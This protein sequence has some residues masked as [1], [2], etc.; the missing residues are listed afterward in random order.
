M[1]SVWFCSVLFS[2]PLVSQLAGAVTLKFVPGPEKGR[3]VLQRG[4]LGACVDLAGRKQP[5]PLSGCMSACPRACVCLYVRVSKWTS[6][7]AH[8]WC[9]PVLG[10]GGRS[11]DA[12]VVVS[13]GLTGYNL[14]PAG[15]GTSLEGEPASCPQARGI[16][17]GT[18][19]GPGHSW[20]VATCP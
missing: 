5:L 14:S 11:N 12:W 6:V 1:L 8:V 18:V 13:F 20:E 7:C 10:R 3:G 9:P 15:G 2:D 16:G 19:A 17:D 4:Q